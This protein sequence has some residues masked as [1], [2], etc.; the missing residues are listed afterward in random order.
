VVKITKKQNKTKQKK[1]AEE[2]C[3]GFGSAPLLCKCGECGSMDT[4]IRDIIL[5]WAD[6]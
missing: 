1:T 5:V 2:H 4:W 6:K 3:F